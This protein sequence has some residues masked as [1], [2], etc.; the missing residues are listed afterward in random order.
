MIRQLLPRLMP[1]HDPQH[2]GHALHQVKFLLRTDAEAPAQV[3]DIPGM[4]TFGEPLHK[5]LDRGHLMVPGIG[6]QHKSAC[7]DAVLD[8]LEDRMPKL[9]CAD[10]TFPR[11]PIGRP[12]DVQGI[13]VFLRQRLPGLNSDRRHRLF[14]HRD[15][16]GE[17]FQHDA[18]VREFRARGVRPLRCVSG[19][20]QT[21]E[22]HGACKIR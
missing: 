1:Y 3:P 18:R 5:L 19:G 7:A 16:A 4:I 8:A 9:V 14:P 11:A 12:L 17:A 2:L 20:E 22:R 10:L 21:E 13:V 6:S 15:I